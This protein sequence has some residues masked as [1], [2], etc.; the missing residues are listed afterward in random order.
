MALN[1]QQALTELKT[2]SF[3]DIQIETT[4]KWAGRAAAAYEL[5]L[6]DNKPNWII[7]A[8]DYR[9]EALEHAALCED[10][11][12]VQHILDTI[13]KYRAKAFRRVYS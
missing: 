13:E 1:L 4:W 8:E 5:S 10:A 6:E 3:T 9:H 2:V 11:D 12:F 7:V